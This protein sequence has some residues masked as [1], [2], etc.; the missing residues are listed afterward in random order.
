MDVGTEIGGGRPP[1]TPPPYPGTPLRVGSRGN[2]VS[3]LQENL[4]RVASRYPTIPRLTVD[5]IFGP[6]TQNTV[7][8]FQRLFGLTADGV[9]GPITWD[10]IM[11]LAF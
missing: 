11:S 7:I 3:I 9:V 8:Q 1:T 4:N 5:G 2:D 10:R 6:A